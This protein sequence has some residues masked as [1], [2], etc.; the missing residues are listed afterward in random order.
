MARSIWEE[1]ALERQEKLGEA[2]ENVKGDGAC[3]LKSMMNL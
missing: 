2:A 3:L 1:A